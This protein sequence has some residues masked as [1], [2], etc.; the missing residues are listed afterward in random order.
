MRRESCMSDVYNERISENLSCPYCSSDTTIKK[1]R[2]SETPVVR[3]KIRDF[4]FQ[5]QIL[6][7]LVVHNILTIVF[8]KKRKKHGGDNILITPFCT[9]LDL[10]FSLRLQTGEL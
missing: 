1:R 4:F 3:W 10:A 2:Y 7:T 8:Q 9:S 6:L 5:A